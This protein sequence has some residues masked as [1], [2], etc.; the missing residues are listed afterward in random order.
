MNRSG[1]LFP[2]PPIDLAHTANRRDL[3]LLGGTSRQLKGPGS[4]A[5]LKGG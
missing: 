5:T 3:A 4:A 2:L 1:T